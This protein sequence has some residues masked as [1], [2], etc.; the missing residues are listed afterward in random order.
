MRCFCSFPVLFVVLFSS[1]KTSSKTKVENI[2]TAQRN[3]MPADSIIQKQKK[4]VDIYATGNQ[5]ADWSLEV[6]LDNLVS[7]KAADGMN[8]NL[9][10]AFGKK[11]TSLQKE[12]YRMQTGQGMLTIEIFDTGCKE[13]SPG[14]KIEVTVG[15][16]HYSGCGRYLFDH[17]LNDSWELES[18]NNDRVVAADFNKGLP[19]VDF[20]LQAN[21]MNGSD[22]CNTISSAIEIK[23]N[24]IKFSVFTGTK[25]SCSKNKAEKIFSTMLSNKLVDY[26]LENNKLV[27][28]LE[29][30]SKLYFKRKTL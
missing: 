12:T 30:D 13:G 22:G 5:P 19:R 7:F 8:L 20:D 2:V 11:E 1:C 24:R 6:D 26:Y 4:G 29:D 18:I 28:Y 27:L 23:G 10:P 15:N 9:L 25:M 14:K 21:K 3:L 17:R 16:K